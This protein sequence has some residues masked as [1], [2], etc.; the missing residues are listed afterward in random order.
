MEPKFTMRAVKFHKTALYRQLGE[1]VRIGRTGG[2]GSILN[3]KAEFDRCYIPRLVV[4]EKDTKVM[5]QEELR[6]HQQILELLEEENKGWRQDKLETRTNRDREEIRR[7]QQ[8][9]SR[10]KGEKREL[11]E[12][13]KRSRRSKRLK[14]EIIGEDWG[15]EQ[16]L[17]NTRELSSALPAQRPGSSK[18][19]SN[20]YLLVQ[21]RS[22]GS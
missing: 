4:E 1:A 11:A 19:R 7:L 6:E 18:E 15:R 3:S 16:P 22:L 12:E 10:S 14:Y 5:E 2:Q 9:E 21:S 17:L 13:F 20:Q 8:I